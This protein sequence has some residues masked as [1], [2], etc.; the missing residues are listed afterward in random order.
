VKQ[1]NK[2][3]IILVSVLGIVVLGVATNKFI[4]GPHR[5]ANN[6]ITQLNTEIEKKEN[7]LKMYRIEK[8][9]LS[10]WNKLSLPN[11]IDVASAE[12][13][14]MLKPLLRKAGLTVDDFQGPPPQDVRGQVNQKKP[15]HTILP[16]TVRAKGTLESLTKAAETLRRIPVMHRVQKVTIDRIDAKDK[17]GKLSI[18]MVIEGMIVY[19]ANNTPSYKPSS[20]TRELLAKL[21]PSNRNFDDMP[22]RN[23]F[24]GYVPP[25]PAPKVEAPIEV[26]SG[27]DVREYIRID[28][29]IPTTQEA[30]LYN[31]YEGTSLRL[32]SKA[33]SGYD[34]FRIM[35]ERDKPVLKGK[36]LRIDPRDVYFQV[37]DDVYVFHFGQTL[38]E[39]MRRP[40]D[41]DEL[42]RLDLKLDADFAKEETKEKTTAKKT[43]TK[44][45]TKKK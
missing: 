23:P 34:V 20:D 30:F 2:L 19:G 21:A 24:L 11:N 6:K 14:Q 27:P 37:A 15:Q 45:V 4:L 5:E 7:D 39:A 13:A 26:P 18:Q 33:R 16:F 44:S 29:I 17:T 42:A 40:I 43:P 9:R 35:D 25:P 36:V 1:D 28:S 10:K 38:A 3:V 12:Y 8:Q 22:L 41:D 31:R 32:R